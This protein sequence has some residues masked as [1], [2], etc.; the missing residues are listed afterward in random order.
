MENKQAIALKATEILLQVD[1]ERRCFENNLMSVAS[2]VVIK[3]AHR[4]SCS[5]HLL[6]VLW[7]VVA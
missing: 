5:A 7:L 2:S 1:G 3:G 4:R 6:E